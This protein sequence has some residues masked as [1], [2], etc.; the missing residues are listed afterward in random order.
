MH[1]GI[2]RKEINLN[3]RIEE[4]DNWN[5][6]AIFNVKLKGLFTPL[7]GLVL[8]LKTSFMVVTKR[9]INYHL[10]GLVCR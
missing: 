4:V 9:M 3:P 7:T 5:L 8:L 6:V 1:L 2:N 10:S